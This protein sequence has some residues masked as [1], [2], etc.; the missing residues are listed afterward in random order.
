M[1]DDASSMANLRRRDMTR[2]F[3][4]AARSDPGRPETLITRHGNASGDKKVESGTTTNRPLFNSRSN[5]S[6]L[7]EN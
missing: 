4:T 2:K 6:C 1:H 7:H 3:L 5:S